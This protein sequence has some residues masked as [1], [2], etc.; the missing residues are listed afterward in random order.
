MISQSPRQ[1][2]HRLSRA[3]IVRASS[4]L[5]ICTVLLGLTTPLV[6]GA[7]PSGPPSVAG[8]DVVATPSGGFGSDGRSFG[9]EHDSRVLAHRSETDLQ[10]TPQNATTA[11]S[12]T[13]RHRLVIRGLDQ[14][15]TYSVQTSGPASVS[16]TERTDAS[17]TST[18]TGLVGPNDSIDVIQFTGHVTLF[19]TDG[20]LRVT[21]DG[22]SVD[23]TVLDGRYIQFKPTRQSPTPVNY[24]FTVNGSTEPTQ[25]AERADIPAVPNT[26]HVAGT[27]S[28]T[29]TDAFYYTG[30][31]TNS[32]VS[33]PLT[34]IID[35]QVVP[36]N[37]ATTPSGSPPSPHETPGPTPNVTQGSATP[38]SPTT[39]PVINTTLPFQVSNL[40]VSSSV[41]EVNTEVTVTVR[42][43]NTG[44][45]RVDAPLEL[46]TGGTVVDSQRV[47]LFP[48]EWQRISFTYEYK[49]P[50]NYTVRIGQLYKQVSIVAEGNLDQQQGRD[51]DTLSF[52]IL[53]IGAI[54]TGLTLVW[55][56][57]R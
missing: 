5:V 16:K 53:V 7:I 50:G 39:T 15:T 26:S 29:D 56:R 4:V 23:P 1:T 24:T 38:H 45:T 46:A 11:Q 35:S 28:A 13:S 43:A 31:I 19:S 12:N 36:V 52:W 22:Q 48:G 30:N 6:G 18:V 37:S 44:N 47:T 8:E 55:I 40:S 33:G 10:A 21:L 17:R 2:R 32:T 20:G 41:A 34:V 57:L 14:R 51:T 54:G 49:N 9:R 25:L 27:L 42:V 3:T